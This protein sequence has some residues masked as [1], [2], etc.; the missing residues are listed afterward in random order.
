MN[1]LLLLRLKNPFWAV[2]KQTLPNSAVVPSSAGGGM[3]FGRPRR[4]EEREGREGVRE[5]VEG[6]GARLDLREQVVLVGR[7][8][9]LRAQAGF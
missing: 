7:P 8:G 1:L 2:P 9:E 5:L 6:P 3:D 4:L